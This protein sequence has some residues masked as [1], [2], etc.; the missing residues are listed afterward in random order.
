MTDWR[1][2]LDAIRVPWV[3]RGANTSRDHVN[4]G[5]PWCGSDDPSHHLSIDEKTGAYFCY[6]NRQ[7][8]GRSLP[9]LLHAYGV[10]Y[11]EVDGLMRTYGALVT[12]PVEQPEKTGQQRTIWDRLDPAD[13]SPLALAYLNSR[14]YAQPRDV[15][16]K[17]DLRVASKGSWAQRIFLPITLEGT[18]CGFTGRTW[19]SDLEPKYL[20]SDA[21]PG[22]LC[23][24]NLPTQHT[25]TLV[26]VEGPMDALGIANAYENKRI[27]GASL[28]GLALPYARIMHIAWLARNVKQILVTLDSDQS[29]ATTQRLI[30]DIE[31]VVSCSVSEKR[32]PPDVKDPGDLQLQHRGIVQWLGNP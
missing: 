11:D 29:L 6:R 18:I 26:L 13:L 21:P 2:L 28:L 19:R 5:C 31:K 8:G 9:Y 12:A 24:P 17:F 14:G 7:H 25:E 10:P 20:M 22:A 23:V 30:Q 3:D 32:L 27:V 4:T 1:P 16:E 15:C